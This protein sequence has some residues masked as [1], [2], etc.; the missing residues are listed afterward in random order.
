MKEGTVGE[1]GCCK[2]GE[3]PPEE[4]KPAKHLDLGASRLQNCK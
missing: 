4:T 1:E 2:L 3:M